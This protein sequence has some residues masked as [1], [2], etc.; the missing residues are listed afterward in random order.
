M[1][2]V[3][4][5]GALSK[6]QHSYEV[7]AD[8]RRGGRWEGQ[9]GSGEQALVRLTVGW[10]EGG[11]CNSP[12]LLSTV[13]FLIALVLKAEGQEERGVFGVLHS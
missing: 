4:S 3:S 6:Q 1:G 7:E 9:A 5:T 2:T 10:A 8:R 13:N 11:G 12:N